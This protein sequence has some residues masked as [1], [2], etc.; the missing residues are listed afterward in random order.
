M[1]QLS[2]ITVFSCVLG[3]SE[4]CKTSF[5]LLNKKG[6]VNSY[7]GSKGC[8]RTNKEYKTLIP[9]YIKQHEL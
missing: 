4:G 6:L 1:D 8:H 5:L 3:T 9:L 7:P 2:K